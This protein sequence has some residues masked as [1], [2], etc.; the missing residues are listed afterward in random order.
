M[1]IDT[2]HM[3]KLKSAGVQSFKITGRELPDDKYYNELRI[4]VKDNW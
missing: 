3:D 4:Y 2:A 1:D